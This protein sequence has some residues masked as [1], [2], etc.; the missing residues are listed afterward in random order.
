MS[1]SPRL[2]PTGVRFRFR[3]AS[4]SASRSRARSPS[5]PKILVCDEPVSSL[6]I[7]V[8]AQI[9]NLFRRL[10]R[11]ARTF[12]PLHHPRP[13]RRPT[14]GRPRLR[15]A[16][17]RDRGAWPRRGGPRRPQPPLHAPADPREHERPGTAG[18]RMTGGDAWPG[19]GPAGRQFTAIGAPP[20]SL[21]RPEI[22]ETLAAEPVEAPRIVRPGPSR[23]RRPGSGPGR[24]RPR[25]PRTRR[26]QAAPPRR[27]RR[28]RRSCRPSSA[29]GSR[30]RRKGSA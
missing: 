12:L 16:S 7:S 17:R 10:Q 20:G 8:Q 4:A 1:A 24:N 2:L 13:G 9:L 3:A 21:G 5:G 29:A 30:R 25:A 23:P 14:D 11:G 15:A 26:R 6:D 28:R 27:T 18:R 22:G 19:P